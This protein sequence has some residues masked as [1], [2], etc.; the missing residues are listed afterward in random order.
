[1]SANSDDPDDQDDEKD[2]AV[3]NVALRPAGLDPS[4]KPEDPADH[5]SE[6]PD[7]TDFDEIGGVAFKRRMG[8]K[9]PSG[10]S[11]RCWN[12]TRGATS[13][14]KGEAKELAVY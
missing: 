4:E 12:G 2:K 8:G 13:C 6:R 10:G 11:S 3:E 14:K 9:N 5:G 7:Q 1:M